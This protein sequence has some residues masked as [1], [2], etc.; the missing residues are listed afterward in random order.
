[1]HDPFEAEDLVKNNCEEP[2]A[3]LNLK[4]FYH[5]NE[6]A[7]LNMKANLRHYNHLKVGR[8]YNKYWTQLQKQI[9][10]FNRTFF[11]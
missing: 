4:N 3:N 7:S 6:T 2:I 1:M 8:S 10:L 5:N 11:L 9:L